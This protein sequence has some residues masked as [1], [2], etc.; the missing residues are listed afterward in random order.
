MDNKLRDAVLSVQKRYTFL[1]SLVVPRVLIDLC[2]RGDFQAALLLKPDSVLVGAGQW[3]PMAGLQN[4][5]PLF[6]N[7]R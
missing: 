6:T 3:I 7:Q 4:P 1:Q 5:M 2:Q